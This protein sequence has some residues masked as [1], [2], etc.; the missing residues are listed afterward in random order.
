[1][2]DP[3]RCWAVT[4]HR[5]PFLTNPPPVVA[6]VR[7]LARVVTQSPAPRAMRSARARPEGQLR[8][9]VDTVQ[10]QSIRKWHPQ[11]ATFRAS[12]MAMRASDGRTFAPAPEGP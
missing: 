9:V 3:S 6:R 4:C 11:A 7:S 12:V 5:S 1:M 8:T 10:P 2:R